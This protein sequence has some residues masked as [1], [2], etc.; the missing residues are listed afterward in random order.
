MQGQDKT[1]HGKH[2]HAEL[3]KPAQDELIREAAQGEV[4]HK[5]DR[6]MKLLRL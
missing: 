2:G 4:L 5:D 6:S 1:R 3:I